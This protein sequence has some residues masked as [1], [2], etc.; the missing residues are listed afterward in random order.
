MIYSFIGL[1]ISGSGVASNFFS[2]LLWYF[3]ELY[4]GNMRN[5]VLGLKAH[6]TLI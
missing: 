1:K 4:K 6:F 3:E 5:S 2:Y